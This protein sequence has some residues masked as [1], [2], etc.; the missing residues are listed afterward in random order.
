[1]IKRPWTEADDLQL[2]ELAERIS[3]QRMTVRMKRSLSAI[4]S[5]A[6]SLGVELKH[7]P[8]IRRRAATGVGGEHQNGQA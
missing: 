7:K 3:P 5:R 8:T 1:M 4:H 6:E 2:R